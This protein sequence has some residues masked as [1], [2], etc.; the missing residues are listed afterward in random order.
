M[1]FGITTP[2]SLYWCNLA[3]KRGKN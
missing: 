2:S 3:S 1:G